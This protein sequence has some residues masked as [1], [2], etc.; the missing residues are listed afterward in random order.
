MTT[1]HCKHIEEPFPQLRQ[2]IKRKKLGD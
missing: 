1:V 2:G